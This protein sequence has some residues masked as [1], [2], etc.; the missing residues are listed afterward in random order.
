MPMSDEWELIEEI[1]HHTATVNRHLDMLRAGLKN[2]K[3]G[4][5]RGLLQ[6]L[7]S[8]IEYYTAQ[9]AELKARRAEIARRLKDKR[10]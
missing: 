8:E 10:R 2:A 3:R 5:D 1:D 6:K 9:L 4:G 7:H